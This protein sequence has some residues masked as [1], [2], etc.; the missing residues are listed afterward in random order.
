MGNLGFQ[1]RWLRLGAGGQQQLNGL[2]GSLTVHRSKHWHGRQPC[3]ATRVHEDKKKP[4]IALLTSVHRRFRNAHGIPPYPYHLHPFAFLL[5]Q[6][7]F[8][9]M[10]GEP[11]A[12]AW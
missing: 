4:S 7:D 1:S 8:F 9:S 2:D 3:G 11:S 5:C 6:V 10:A 12:L